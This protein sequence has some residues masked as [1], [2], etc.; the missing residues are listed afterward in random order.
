MA[1]GLPERILE[2]V[3]SKG[4][5]DSCQYACNFNIDHQSVVGAIK[6]LE[7]LGDVSIDHYIN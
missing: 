1:E 2:A 3:A 5:V 7:S 4:Q 6:S